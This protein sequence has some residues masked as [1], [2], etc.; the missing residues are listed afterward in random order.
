[1]NLAC[2][3]GR[4]DRI[5]F[6]HDPNLQTIASDDPDLVAPMVRLVL[7]LKIERQWPRLG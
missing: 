6:D 3:G 7:K 4:N 1:M 5:S 2:S